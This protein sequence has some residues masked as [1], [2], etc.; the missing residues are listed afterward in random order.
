[1]DDLTATISS[2]PGM[3]FVVYDKD[4]EVL[5]VEEES[6]LLIGINDKIVIE[7]TENYIKVTILEGDFEGKK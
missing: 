5:F 7:T 2:Q 4:G 3:T 6:D 1:M